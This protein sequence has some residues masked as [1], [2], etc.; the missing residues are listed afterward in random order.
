VKAGMTVAIIGIA[1]LVISTVGATLWI[2][3]SESGRQRQVKILLF[4]LYFWVLVF[5]QLILVSLGYSVLA[6]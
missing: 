6:G 4:A 1:I 3:R 5:V 2:K